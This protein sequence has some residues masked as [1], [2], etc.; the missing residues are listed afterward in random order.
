M[1]CGP[2]IYPLMTLN[3]IKIFKTNI[4]DR[5]NADRVIRMLE[6]DYPEFMI[7]IDTEDCDNVLRVEG[8]RMFSAEDIIDIIMVIGFT[9]E[10][11]N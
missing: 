5:N 10:E 7:T 4:S 9:V 2:A 11:M 8:N 3:M 1:N 6:D